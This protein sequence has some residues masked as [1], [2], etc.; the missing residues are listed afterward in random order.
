MRALHLDTLPLREKSSRASAGPLA[1]LTD[2]AELAKP[3][4][5]AASATAGF[6]ALIRVNF[7]LALLKAEWRLES[8]WRS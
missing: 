6:A 1:D 4:D 5:P 2:L 8:R 3:A 7:F